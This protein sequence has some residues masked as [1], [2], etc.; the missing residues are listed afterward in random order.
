MG[1][2][3]GLA[4]NFEWYEKLPLEGYK[5]LVT[6][7]KELISTMAQKLRVQGAEVLELPTIATE[8][9]EE[10]DRLSLIHI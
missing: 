5:V 7:P 1:R 10:N 2:V 9:I 4:E 8:A 6:R 3:C